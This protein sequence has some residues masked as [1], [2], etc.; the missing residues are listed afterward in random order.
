MS[1]IWPFHLRELRVLTDEKG[2]PRIFEFRYGQDEY[3][4]EVGSSFSFWIK[5]GMSTQDL[6]LYIMGERW[7]AEHQAVDLDTAT[8]GDQSVP[9]LGER[10]SAI[11]EMARVTQNERIQILE[12]LFFPSEQR[13]LALV[14]DLESGRAFVVGNG[15]A[16][17]KVSHSDA[18]PWRRLAI[19]IG[20][21]LLV[22][23]LE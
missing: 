23:K 18:A 12:G 19:A 16:I 17:H 9:S 6:R 21:M 8:S 1:E 11:K 20:Q 2:A 3:F 10:R 5:D 22:S 15:I 13:Y 14:K 7:F 4:V